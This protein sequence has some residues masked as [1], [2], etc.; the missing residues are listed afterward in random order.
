MKYRILIDWWEEDRCYVARVPELQG[1]VTDGDTPEEALARVHEAIELHLE[2]LADEGS[3][4]PKPIAARKIAAQIPFRGGQ[5][6]IR[7]LMIEAQK[8]GTSI[9]EVLCSLVDSLEKAPESRPRTRSA[10]RG[11]SVRS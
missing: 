2:C 8:R 1:V 6:R 3:A 4:S 5:Q 7:T 11:T 9:S 10:R